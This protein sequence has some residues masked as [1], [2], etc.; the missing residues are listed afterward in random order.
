MKSRPFEILYIYVRVRR[1]KKEAN[2]GGLSDKIFDAY[3]TKDWQYDTRKDCGL[4]NIAY[5]KA[6]FAQGITNSI[7]NFALNLVDATCTGSGSS[8]ADSTPDPSL[9][10]GQLTTTGEEIKTDIQNLLTDKGFNSIEELD[11]EIEITQMRID[12]LSKELSVVSELL[13]EYN[14]LVDKQNSEEISEEESSRLKELINSLNLLEGPEEVLLEQQEEQISTVKRLR[15]LKSLREQIS[16]KEQT[17]IRL[18]GQD[19]E[20][21]IEELINDNTSKFTEKLQTLITA[22]RN[23]SDQAT[24]DAAALALE[25]VYNDWPE[26]RD[27]PLHIQNGYKH[28]ENYI[29]AAKQ[30]QK[31][32]G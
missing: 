9:S 24:I 17:L 29:D 27:R 31:P 18:E 1:K 10:D 20:N 11:A 26:E 28:A 14:M 12:A 22:I 21:A 4:L 19:G 8:R 6:S 23:N 16:T 25:A 2:M 13:T 32:Q 7:F 3:G 5:Q 15:E 30:R